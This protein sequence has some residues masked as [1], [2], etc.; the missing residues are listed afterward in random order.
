[1]ERERGRP[2]RSQEAHQ[3]ERN[4]RQELHAQLS[5]TYRERGSLGDPSD[6]PSTVLRL[7]RS[8][9]DAG[10]GLLLWRQDGG[11]GELALAAAGGFE[12]SPED[13]AVV[14]HLAEEVLERDQTVREENLETEADRRTAADEEIEDLIAVP[15]YLQEEFHGVMVR[16]NNPGGF[17]DYGA[18]R[19]CSRWVTKPAWC[20]R[21][22]GSGGSCAPRSWCR[23]RAGEHHRGQR[24]LYHG[25]KADWLTS[26]PAE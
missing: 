16:A 22:S 19:C 5:R 10:K 21:T 23:G 25:A 14:R 13:S 9:L 7:T 1:M 4:W 2:S 6:V 11:D 17:D 12:H 3:T 26:L 8:L 18:M 15:I 20:S 24:P